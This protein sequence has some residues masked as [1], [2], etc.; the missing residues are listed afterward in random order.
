MS[1]SI[2]TA[3]PDDAEALAHLAATTFTETFGPQYP[4]ED[5]REFLASS[6]EI[7]GLKH[8]LAD[9]RHQWL[10]AESADG[11]AIAYAQAGPCGLPHPEATPDQGELKRIYVLRSHQGLGL[12]RELMD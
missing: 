12:S 9:T 11:E 8:E 5:L 4:P 7:E 1:V 2:R 6:Y 10:I 3:G